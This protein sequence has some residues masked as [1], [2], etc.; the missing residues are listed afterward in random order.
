LGT[1]NKTATENLLKSGIGNVHNVGNLS[2]A[3]IQRAR[4][5]VKKRSEDEEKKSYGCIPALCFEILKLNP[6]SR[7][8]CQAD[9]EGRFYRVFVRLK[10]S[11]HAIN[12]G[13]VPIIEV[14]GAFMK[15][16]YIIECVC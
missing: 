2:H 14:D 12:N 10:S 6:G 8:S 11:V 4:D 13:C 7:I 15:H 3:M 5:V 16:P 1:R 9:S